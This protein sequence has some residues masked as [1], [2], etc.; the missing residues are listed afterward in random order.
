MGVLRERMHWGRCRRARMAGAAELA[1]E[2]NEQH[3]ARGRAVRTRTN[4][5]V[6]LFPLQRSSDHGMGICRPTTRLQ[7]LAEIGRPH[8]ADRRRLEHPRAM[9]IGGEQQWGIQSRRATG[10]D[11]KH[12]LWQGGETQQNSTGLL[13]TM[14]DHVREVS[15]SASTGKPSVTHRKA[16]SFSMSR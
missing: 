14:H 4:R 8:A 15:T 11:S 3:G 7:T 10:P 16:S 2:G 1:G 13:S 12:G 9:A 6:S 5:S